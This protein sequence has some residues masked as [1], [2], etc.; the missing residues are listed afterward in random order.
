[1]RLVVDEK[2][3]EKRVKI[4]G[5]APF[6]G[7]I[8]LIVPVVI[9]FIRPE[10]SWATMII[11]P[12]GF[13]MS[14]VGGYLGTRYLGPL[15][16]HTRVPEALKGLDN[17]YTLLI[18]KTPVPFVL[19]DPG[20]ATTIS[21]RSH[22][23]EISYQNGKWRHREKM[24]MLKQFAGM[25]GLG[26]PHKLAE[27]DAEEFR[28]FLRKNL[29]GEVDVPVRSVILF[30]DPDVKLDID[31]GLSVPAF[32][33]SELKRWLRRDG[34]RVKMSEDAQKQLCAVLDIEM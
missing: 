28:R 7:L 14:L 16:H 32:R 33:A 4:G 29:S 3:I 23:G 1:M 9:V 21:V 5:L 20:G 13:L 27:M 12:I 18:Y 24:R 19:I 34:R 30:V 31:D 2:H 15:A 22:G 17:T 25:E 10:W 26:K 8:L 11:I 6:V